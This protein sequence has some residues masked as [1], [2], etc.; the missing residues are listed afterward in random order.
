MLPVH[1]SRHSALHT[2]FAK[3]FPALAEA[4]VFCRDRTEN[5]GR[6]GQCGGARVN[7]AYLQ[8]MLKWLEDRAKTESGLT[9]KKKGC[10]SNDTDSK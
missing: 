3:A 1:A 5:S 2:A 10:F 9:D 4:A 7:R 6:I 8:G